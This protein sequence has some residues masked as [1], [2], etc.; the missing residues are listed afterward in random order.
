MEALLAVGLFCMFFCVFTFI[1]AFV[2]GFG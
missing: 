1:A 2:R